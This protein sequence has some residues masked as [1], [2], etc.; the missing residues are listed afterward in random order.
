MKFRIIEKVVNGEKKYFI[1]EKTGHF[2]WWTAVKEY[3]PIPNRNIQET[4]FEMHIV[5]FSDPQT[6]EK[7]IREE[8]KKPKDGSKVIKEFEI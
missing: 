7:W 3:Y 1:E 8:A 2:G 4:K 5:M 6:A